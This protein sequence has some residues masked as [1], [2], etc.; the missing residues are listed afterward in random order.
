MLLILGKSPSSTLTEKGCVSI[1]RQV[2]QGKIVFSL[3]LD[4]R[5]I[6]TVDENI[7]T[8]NKLPNASSKVRLKKHL[9]L[10]GK[11]FDQLMR[12]LALTQAAI[13]VANQ[14]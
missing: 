11:F 1:K 7:V 14:L 13:F 4:K 12:S 6:K 5:Y 8:L 10:R 3:Y 9:H 2:R